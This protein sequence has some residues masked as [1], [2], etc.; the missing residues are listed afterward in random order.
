MRTPADRALPK[1]MEI[2]HFFGAE[3]SGKWMTAKRTRR[4]LARNVHVTRVRD[5]E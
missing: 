2:S 1:G 3:K 4:Q 5:D